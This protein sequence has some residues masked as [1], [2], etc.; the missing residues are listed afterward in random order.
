MRLLEILEARKNPE[1][2]VKI[3]SHDALRAFAE[4]Y[5]TEDIF[6]TFTFVE[7]FG[8]NPSTKYKTPVGLYCYPLSYLI[9]VMFGDIPFVNDA[10]YIWIFR[11]NFDKNTIWT[12]SEPT[13]PELERKIKISYKTVVGRPLRAIASSKNIFGSMYLNLQAAIKNEKTKTYDQKISILSY[14]ILKSAGL[15]GVVDYGTGTIHPY[16]PTQAVFFNI[17][18]L[19]VLDKILNTERGNRGETKPTK[20]VADPMYSPENAVWYAIKKLGRRFSKGEPLI[21]TDADASYTYAAKLIKG[22]FPEGEKAISY[23]QNMSYKYAKD[24]IGGRFPEGEKAIATDGEMS[25]K[26]AKDVIGGRFPEG[27]KNLLKNGS[28]WVFP[29]IKDVI[30]GRWPDAEPR[31]IEYP[32]LAA[33]YAKTILKQRWPEAEDSIQNGPA[34]PGSLHPSEN[35]WAEYAEHFGIE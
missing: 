10:K 12:V 17:S 14:K 5:G 1:V 7:K 13:S 26:Y 18:G 8:V 3:N 33:M 23:N 9:E 31:L 25:Y 24:V 2:N 30:K 20:E 15:N 6:A 22:R 16:E 32:M 11:N 34:F 21:A 4:K 35:A 28:G 29:Y 19:K 27:E